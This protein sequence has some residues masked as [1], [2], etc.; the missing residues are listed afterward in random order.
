MRGRS[1][2]RRAS[3]GEAELGV[4]LTNEEHGAIERMT[5]IG[6]GGVLRRDAPIFKPGIDLLLLK[7]P[8]DS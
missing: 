8:S 6:I 7:S 4:I 3:D 5:P 2:E 1:S